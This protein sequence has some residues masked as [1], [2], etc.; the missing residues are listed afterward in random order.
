MSSL[1]VEFKIYLT[2]RWI[3]KTSIC[4]PASII[5]NIT[6]QSHHHFSLICLTMCTFSY[7]HLFLLSFFHQLISE[8]NQVH[9]GDFTHCKQTLQLIKLYLI[10]NMK[11]NGGSLLAKFKLPFLSILWCFFYHNIMVKLTVSLNS[12]SSVHLF[13]CFPHNLNYCCPQMWATYKMCTV[14]KD[15]M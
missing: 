2:C 6:N 10:Q 9:T 8:K 7:G 13:V 4:F 11:G 12:L 3:G 15:I 14:I 1:N 5:L